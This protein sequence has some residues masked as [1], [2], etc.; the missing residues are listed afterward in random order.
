MGTILTVDD[1]R[2]V[3]T[4]VSKQVKELGFEVLEAED[5]EQGLC[6]LKEVVVDL[7]LLDVTMPVLD[8][9]GMLA[10]L[11]E[12]GNKTPVIMLTSESKRS[13][14]AGAMQLGIND[15]ILKPFKPE[16]LRQKI[17]GVLKIGGADVEEAAIVQSAPPPV[18]AAKP[19]EPAARE[20][21]QFID[22]LVVDDMENVQKRLRQP[23]PDY[24][25]VNGVTSAQA[26]VGMCRD[27]VYRVILVDS[28]I[29]DVS[30]STLAGQLKLLQPH[31]A[32][33]ALALRSTNSAARE[34]KAQGFE[35]VVWKP[36]TQDSIEDFTLQ[37]FDNQEI[38]VIEDNLL[39]LKPFI[40]KPERME[41][42]CLRLAQMVPQLMTK[43]ASA[44]YETLIVD[45][46]QVPML[47]E[48]V[49]KLLTTICKQAEEIGLTV[50]L[51]GAE[52]LQR[53]LAGFDETK[54]IRC[55]KS[56]PEARAANG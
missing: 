43:V 34:L 40:G 3:R 6:K 36:F 28:E 26:A 15:Y 7:I 42:Y 19:G 55:F 9:P 35:E 1:S 29:P 44:C 50:T 38:L 51:V 11:R 14:V 24:L 16:E 10:K 30:S 49:P 21:R 48:R 12:S 39:R 33:L 2:A 45:V 46:N 5:G 31:A 20:G 18:A 32:V 13:V 41:R 17:L 25:T 53:V 54:G 4:I 56:V 27:H 47:V 52:G 22:V 37:Y 8:G 23:L